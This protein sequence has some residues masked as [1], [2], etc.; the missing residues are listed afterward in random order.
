M[1]KSW[2][3]AIDTRYTCDVVYQ[4]DALI[5]ARTQGTTDDSVYL[6][7]F[8]RIDRTL[9]IGLDDLIEQTAHVN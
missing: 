2:S 5:V 3:N 7:T 1:T 4:L 9:A 8:D 6:A